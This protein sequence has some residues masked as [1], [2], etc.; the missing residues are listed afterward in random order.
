[1]KNTIEKQNK[2]I[3]EKFPLELIL[4]SLDTTIMVLNDERQIV[5]HNNALLDLVDEEEA[6]ILGMRPGEVLSVFTF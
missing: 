6:E 1:M 3:S 2:I 5:H 4:N